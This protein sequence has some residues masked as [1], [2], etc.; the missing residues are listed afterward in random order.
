VAAMQGE[1]LMSMMGDLSFAGQ[2]I[3][4]W[5]LPKPN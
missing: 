5:N 4:G 2:A 3:K 1:F